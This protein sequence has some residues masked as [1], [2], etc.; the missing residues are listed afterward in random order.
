MSLPRMPLTS[1]ADSVRT[2]QTVVRPGP[3]HKTALCFMG[4]KT[5]TQAIAAV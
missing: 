4:G 2:Q 3:A 5:N 1:P